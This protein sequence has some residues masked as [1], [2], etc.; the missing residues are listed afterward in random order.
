MKILRATFLAVVLFA[1]R[2]FAGQGWYLLS[3]PAVG[4]QL[5]EEAPLRRWF[6]MMSHDTARECEANMAKLMEM[7]DEAVKS[8]TTAATK[9]KASRL[10]LSRCIALDDPRLAK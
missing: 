4:G 5:D 8:D 2:V 7:A 9:L 1:A 3:P 6:H 10:A